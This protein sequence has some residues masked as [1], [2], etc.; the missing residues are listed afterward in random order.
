MSN[1]SSTR[2]ASSTM[3]RSAA[4]QPRALSRNGAIQLAFLPPDLTKYILSR[5]G[6]ELAEKNGFYSVTNAV[7]E[8]GL[9]ALGITPSSN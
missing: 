2:A 6:Q 9:K 3:M 4:E 8:E 5:D 1:G 7:R